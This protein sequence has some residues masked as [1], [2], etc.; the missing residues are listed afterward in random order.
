MNMYLNLVE[1]KIIRLMVYDFV[2]VIIK[3][4]K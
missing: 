2:Y 3:N 1:K 4:D